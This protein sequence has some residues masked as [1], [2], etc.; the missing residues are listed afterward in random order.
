ERGDLQMFATVLGGLMPMN[1]Y[2]SQYVSNE[3]LAGA[4]IGWVVLLAIPLLRQPE[5]FRLRQ[6]VPIGLVLGLALLTK[7]T[8]LLIVFPVAFAIV[9]AGGAGEGSA[10]RVAARTIEALAIV[11]GLAALIAGWYYLRNYIELGR[12]FIGGWDAARGIEWWQDPGYRTPSQ[13][14][15]FGDALIRPI[16]CGISSFW[17]GIYSTLWMDGFISGMAE[18]DAMPHWNYGFLFPGMWFALLPTLAILI[19]LAATLSRPVKSS[20]SGLILAALCVGIYFAVLL[21][22]FSTAR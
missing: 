13:L 18:L 20:S 9:Y 4:L 12:P 22:H 10:R 7:V 17:D 8:A 11:L 6:C 16:F 3:P 5:L 14:L 21:L 2:R 19:G 15:A 1:V